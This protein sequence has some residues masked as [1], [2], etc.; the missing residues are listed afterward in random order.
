MDAAPIWTNLK[1]FPWQSF[2]GT[3]DILSGGYPCQPFSLAGK[4]LG[5]ED[6]RHLWPFIANGI[7]IMRPRM[8]FF[9]NV[10]GHVSLG[11]S[12]V[13]SDLEELG[14]EVSW[15]VFSA[16]ECGAPHRRKRIFIL[17]NS[18]QLFSHVCNY[19]A[20]IIPCKHSV[21]E[22]GDNSRAADISYANV[23]FSQ[24]A[25]LTCGSD[26][27]QPNANSSSQSWGSD[28]ANQVESGVGRMANGGADRVDRLR[29]LGNG[30]VPATAELAFKTLFRNLTK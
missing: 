2:R 16:S 30:V 24:G 13:I 27:E 10:E 14:Y 15:G 12:T 1:T 9:E 3:V 22:F 11:L 23:P 26:T 7:E 19:N 8:C 20:G 18:S 28:P 29:L 25:R 4:R 21:S 17:A 5:I 6:P